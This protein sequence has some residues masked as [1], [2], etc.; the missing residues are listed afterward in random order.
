[1]TA[2]LSGFYRQR[3]DGIDVFV[4]LTPKSSADRVDRIETTGDGRAY[5]VGR[6][7]AVPEKAA[8]NAAVERVLAE[9][10]AVPRSTVEVIAG[11][12]SR[13]KTV[14]I[15]TNTPSVLEALQSLA[16]AR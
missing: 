5:L 13:L 1:M 4:R 10:I 7:R 3:G 11:Q 12:T 16:T 6:V 2:E 15:G 8:A 14:R 9:T